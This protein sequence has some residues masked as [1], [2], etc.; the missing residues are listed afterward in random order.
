MA[1]SLTQTPGIMKTNLTLCLIV[2]GLLT[3]IVFPATATAQRIECYVLN[4]PVKQLDGILNI[5][6][7]DFKGRGQAGR[8]LT[9]YMITDLLREDRGITDRT[10]GFLGMGR[11]IEG[12]TYVKGVKTNIFTVIER[13]QIDKVMREQ[14]LGLSGALDESTAARL[15][16][17]LGLDAIIIGELG[18]EKKDDN[19]RNERRR[20]DG[21]TYTQRCT[22]RR[23]RVNASMKIIRVESG[24]ILGTE[25]VNETA[26]DRKCDE[27]RNT[28]ATANELLDQALKQTAREF[29]N[30]F[31]PVYELG[32]YE[33]ERIGLRRLRRQTDEAATHLENNNI[34]QA[35]PIILSVYEADPYNP[36]AAYNLGILNEI[37]GSYDKAFEYYNIAHQL[38]AGNKTYFDAVNRARKGIELAIYLE[39]INM[40]IQA[41]NLAYE[42]PAAQANK[43]TI[44]GRSS[45]RVAVHEQPDSG[46]A[47][48]ARVPG[49]L[50]FSFTDKTG[51]WYRIVLLNQESG[52]VHQSDVN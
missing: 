22:E 38:D 33:L 11:T 48:I 12:I 5:G 35:F 17:L 19:T 10:G 9:D 13:N 7:V 25:T 30:Y 3:S 34:K 36:K 14:R 37:T 41:Y 47:V 23:V 44:K 18:W 4:A 27:Y 51:E 31:T 40:P 15:G 24:E 43:I 2:I 29:V 49:G 1:E 28:V 16:Q 6:I 21:S 39:S 8:Q 26:T 50:E 45:A 42:E 20:L 46:S 52:Y 32:R